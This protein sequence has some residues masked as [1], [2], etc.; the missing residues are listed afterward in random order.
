MILPVPSLPYAGR[1][2]VPPSHLPSLFT[3]L[4]AAP[5]MEGGCFIAGAVTKTKPCQN[6]LAGNTLDGQHPPCLLQFFFTE[7][8][9][10]YIF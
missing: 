4:L 6:L 3:I 10:A 2:E 8:H 7:S 5:G 9:P 1:P